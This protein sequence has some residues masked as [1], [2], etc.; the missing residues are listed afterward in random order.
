MSASKQWVSR[1]D[2]E[3]GNQ[4]TGRTLE[5][6]GAKLGLVG[7]EEDVRGVRDNKRITVLVRVGKH[8]CLGPS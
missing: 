7:S 8:A 6:G 5:G 1:R 4:G 2:Q 3:T